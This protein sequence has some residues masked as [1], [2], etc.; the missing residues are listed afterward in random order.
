MLNFQKVVICP[1]KATNIEL[2]CE[3]NISRRTHY[4]AL[5]ILGNSN[6][7]GAYLTAK[8]QVKTL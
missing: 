3:F 1:E 5:K 7:D 2:T 8:F 4:F 6:N